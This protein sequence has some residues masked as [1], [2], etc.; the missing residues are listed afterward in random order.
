M[1]TMPYSRPESFQVPSRIGPVGGLLLASGSAPVG[2]TWIWLLH[3]HGA[4]AHDTRPLL[5][6]LAEATQR[7]QLPELAVAVP[8]GPW[9]D[10]GSWWVDTALPVETALLQDVLPAVEGSLG[11]RPSPVRRCVAGISMGGAAALRW[12]LAHH[13]L[14]GSAALLSPAVYET[15]PP[16]SSARTT[17]AF[18]AGPDRFV[19][20]RWHETMDFRA[21]LASRERSGPVTRVATVVGDREPAQDGGDGAAAD[22][23]LQAVRLHAALKRHPRIRSSLRIVGGGHDQATWARHIAEVVGRAVGQGLCHPH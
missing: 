10:R 11:D 5:A 23:D 3:G 16:D 4:G 20:R 6:A 22:L 9:L 12:A 13:D 18:G 21:L 17:G 1:E 2:R 8:D 15:P 7:G 14:F 19:E